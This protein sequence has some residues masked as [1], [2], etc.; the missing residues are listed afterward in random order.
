M[1]T[2]L[3]A[4]LLARVMAG[5]SMAARIAMMAMT[6]SSSIS[7]KPLLIFIKCGVLGFTFFVS[8]PGAR[9]RAG[10][11]ARGSVCRVLR[12]DAGALLPQDP[13]SRDRA[14]AQLSVRSCR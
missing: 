8:R 5:K 6:T 3:Y 12:D 14:A 10:H 13:E 11:A 2:V 9:E 4:L 7:V 1:Q